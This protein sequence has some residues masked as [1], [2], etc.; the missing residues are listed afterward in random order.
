M[1]YRRRHERCS[2]AHNKF[3]SVAGKSDIWVRSLKDGRIDK[4]DEIRLVA[5][6]AVLF[7]GLYRT[8]VYDICGSTAHSSK[9][10]GN[11]GNGSRI[12]CQRISYRVCDLIGH[13]FHPG[14]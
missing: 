9:G 5:Y 14:R 6:W 4:K 7:K 10:M 3:P 1:E 12:D 13:I 11:V 8:R 2:L